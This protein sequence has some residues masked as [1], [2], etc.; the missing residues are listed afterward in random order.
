MRTQIV[1][2]EGRES[3]NRGPRLRVESGGIVIEAETLDIEKSNPHGA[4]SVKEW[5]LSTNT[6]KRV[7]G[8]EGVVKR[9]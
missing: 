5:V 1:R 9:H 3:G 8:P 7:G 6:T 4:T 2:G